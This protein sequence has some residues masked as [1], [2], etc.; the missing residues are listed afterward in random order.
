MA[1]FSVEVGSLLLLWNRYG[2][3]ET[4]K[5]G[6]GI[7]NRYNYYYDDLFASYVYL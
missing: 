6:L 3:G 1:F 7:C 2:M 5:K 4:N